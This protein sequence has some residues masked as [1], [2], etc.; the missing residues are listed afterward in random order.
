MAIVLGISFVLFVFF[1][2]FVRRKFNFLILSTHSLFY[3]LSISEKVFKE[4]K[5][6]RVGKVT[7]YGLT[8]SV[9]YEE[10]NC[11]LIP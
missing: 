5:K 4:I 9:A 2:L 11:V 3:P 6:M 10:R 1:F 8:R 7:L